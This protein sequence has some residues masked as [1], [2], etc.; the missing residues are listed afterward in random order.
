[1]KYF[2]SLSLVASLYRHPFV[3]TELALWLLLLLLKLDLT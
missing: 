3:V 1:M 2:L